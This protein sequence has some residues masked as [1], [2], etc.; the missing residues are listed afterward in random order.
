M[1]PLSPKQL[2]SLKVAS[3]EVLSEATQFLAALIRINTTNPPGLNYRTIANVIS[4]HLV[5]LD[6]DTEILT[7]AKE[8]ELLLR[9]RLRRLLANSAYAL[10]V[11]KCGSLHRPA[12]RLDL[13]A[14]SIPFLELPPDSL[15]TTMYRPRHTRSS[16]RRSERA[17]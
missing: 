10:Q 12:L 4:D 17:R 2:A 14:I 8:G 16:R 11:G 7:V 1:P 6:Y 15:V 9:A 13:S 5:E 3:F